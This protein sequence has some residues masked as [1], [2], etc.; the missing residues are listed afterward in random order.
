MN[1]DE[2]ASLE[3]RLHRLGIAQDVQRLM[4]A[5]IGKLPVKDTTKDSLTSRSA[6]A[7]VVVGE[8]GVALTKGAV[9]AGKGAATAGADAFQRSKQEHVSGHPVPPVDDVTT[10][11]ERLSRLHADGHLDDDEYRDAKARVI[12]GS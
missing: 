9:E 4:A 6:T 10:R 7:V 2:R 8:T 5:G 12:V 3:E 1:S 11:L